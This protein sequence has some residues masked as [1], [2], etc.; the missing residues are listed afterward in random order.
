VG[1]IVIMHIYQ[2]P[3][4]GANEFWMQYENSCDGD[5]S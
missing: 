3:D 2:R 5:C 1:N 4:T